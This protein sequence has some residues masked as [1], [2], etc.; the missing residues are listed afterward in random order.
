MFD[1]IAFVD[2]DMVKSIENSH[3][4]LINADLSK[5]QGKLRDILIKAKPN[6]FIEYTLNI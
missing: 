5:N 3:N 1:K 2:P 6:F 4:L